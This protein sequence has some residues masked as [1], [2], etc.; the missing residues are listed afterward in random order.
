MSCGA[1]LP[2]WLFLT[3][4]F[5]EGVIATLVIFSIYL[6]GIIMAVITGIIFQKLVFK[7]QSTPFI[8]EM[9]AYRTPNIKTL[10]RILLDKFKSFVKKAG[11]IILISSV[12][13]WVLQ[14]FSFS[15]DMVSDPDDSMMAKIGGVFAYIFKPMGFG[16][17]QATFAILT[18]FIAK[19]VVVT[20]F[21]TLSG[22]GD[23][24][25][26]EGLMEQVKT[27][28]I[29]AG[30]FIS[31]LAVFCFM[32]FNLLAPPCLAAIGTISQEIKSKKWTALILLYQLSLAYILTLLIYGV[33]SLVMVII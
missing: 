13:V 8:M 10:F 5:F 2:I 6:I 9:P 20:T 31:P 4:A 25:E 24:L 26:N 7:Q 11:T 14:T 19:E 28:I 12:I 21:G 15:F 16:T 1:K 32:V 33:G 23:P 17:W 29:G 3:A 18:G 30:I 27:W 22:A